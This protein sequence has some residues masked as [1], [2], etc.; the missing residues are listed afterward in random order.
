[1]AK[2]HYAELT[3]DELN[4]LIAERLGW[5]IQEAPLDRFYKTPEGLLNNR[6]GYEWATSLNDA[7]SLCAEIRFNIAHELCDFTRD[8]NNNIIDP[9]EVRVWLYTVY[10]GFKAD[11][12]AVDR[13]LP[14]AICEA[15]LK[16]QD[17]KNKPLAS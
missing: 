10:M 13:D 6:S 14:R 7:F 15:W 5:V 9:G 12:L 17:H 3:D 1:M 2:Q 11:V 16:W 4:L 8:A